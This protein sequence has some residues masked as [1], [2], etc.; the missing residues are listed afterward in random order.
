[1]LCML[2]PS[3]G[4]EKIEQSPCV[5]GEKQ[6][7]DSDSSRGNIGFQGRES[8]FHLPE[9]FHSQSH[10]PSSWGGAPSRKKI[11]EAR[12]MSEQGAH[13]L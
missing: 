10:L 9:T 6:A 5:P 2:V 4:G 8:Q 13:A 7:H 1:M 12:V 11:L 3:S